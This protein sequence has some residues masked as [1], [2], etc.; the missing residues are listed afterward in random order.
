M[1]DDD[2]LQFREWFLAGK[3]ERLDAYV[4]EIF[5]GSYRHE[6]AYLKEIINQF[7]PGGRVC[8]FRNHSKIFAGSGPKF[9]F[10]IESSANINTNPRT[11]NTTITIGADIFNF[12]KD[13]FDDIK[14]FIKED[15]PDWQP[16]LPEKNK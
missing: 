6:Y 5:P 12:Y 16:W 15:F 2:V 14:S 8:V 3:I 10:A 7:S 1:A 11:E 4:G 9:Q 13:F